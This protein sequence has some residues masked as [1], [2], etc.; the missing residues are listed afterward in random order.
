M[1][2][3]TPRKHYLCL[4]TQGPQL[5]SVFLP[6]FTS[7]PRQ[8]YVLRTTVSPSASSTLSGSYGTIPGGNNCIGSY[9]VQLLFVLLIIAEKDKEGNTGLTINTWFIHIK[10]NINL[11]GLQ[12]YKSFSHVSWCSEFKARQKYF[13]KYTFLTIHTSTQKNAI[14]LHT[15]CMY[16]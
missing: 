10:M 6:H 11:S 3:N 15:L 9:T 2:K 12:N 5:M 14:L 13:H 1:I 8:G 7:I 16:K 4:S